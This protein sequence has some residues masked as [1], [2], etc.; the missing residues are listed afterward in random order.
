[1]PETR[2]PVSKPRAVLTEVSKI[3]V[4]EPEL[5]VT[6]RF[7]TDHGKIFERVEC[8]SRGVVWYQVVLSGR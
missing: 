5:C 4:N 8:R 2:I 1:M 6:T 3:T 7:R